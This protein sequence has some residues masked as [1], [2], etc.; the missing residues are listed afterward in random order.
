MIPFKRFVFELLF[1][2]SSMYQ[3][4]KLRGKFHPKLGAS[5]IFL[6]FIFFFFNLVTVESNMS[7]LPLATTQ[8]VKPK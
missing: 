2:L 8:N 7:N 4:A 5:H 1:K 6:H 3:K